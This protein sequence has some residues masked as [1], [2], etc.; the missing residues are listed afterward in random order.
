MM[1]YYIHGDSW[2]N[3]V[4]NGY[5]YIK[6]IKWLIVIENRAIYDYSEPYL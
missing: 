2:S 6:N 5:R 4:N 3:M 1:V